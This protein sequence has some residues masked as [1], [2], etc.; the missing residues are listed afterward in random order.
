MTRGSYEDV[1]SPFLVGEGTTG[2]ALKG[3][4]ELNSNDADRPDMLPYDPH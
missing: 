3:V 2:V 4:F 1:T